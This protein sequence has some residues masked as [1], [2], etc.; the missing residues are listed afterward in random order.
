MRV[1]D[2]GGDGKRGRTSRVIKGKEASAY[3]IRGYRY[4]AAVI[5]NFL[6]SGR[7]RFRN[8]SLVDAKRSSIPRSSGGG[9]DND[10]D[11]DGDTEGRK[12][13]EILSYSILTSQIKSNSRKTCRRQ[14]RRR[15]WERR[16]RSG[17]TPPR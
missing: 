12:K 4:R 8:G 17:R 2:D 15:V 16:P 3:A 5:F 6:F 13:Y 7:Y 11:D 1:S 9:G 14:R 10:D